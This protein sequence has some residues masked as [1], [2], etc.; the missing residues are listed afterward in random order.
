ML[1]SRVRTSLPLTLAS[2]ALGASLVARTTAPPH[3]HAT[4]LAEIHVKMK[5]EGAPLAVAATIGLRVEPMF[6]HAAHDD[7]ARWLVVTAATA[8]PDADVADQIAADPEVEE[9]FVAPHIDLPS[10]GASRDPF[11]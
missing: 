7:R 6:A 4:H 3:A 10:V 11:D 8:G 1:A 2:L 9:A 5:A